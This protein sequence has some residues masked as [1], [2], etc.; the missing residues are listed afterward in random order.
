MTSGRPR[1]SFFARFMIA[2]TRALLLAAGLIGVVVLSQQ[3]KP[4]SLVLGGILACVASIGMILVV[5]YA[6][7][8]SAKARPARDRQRSAGVP[9]A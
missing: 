8:R 4:P 2:Y 9:T 3:E 1:R 7:T 5:E 6:I